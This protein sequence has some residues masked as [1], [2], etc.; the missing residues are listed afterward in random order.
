M[1]LRAGRRSPPRRRR[2]P[3]RQRAARGPRGARGVHA[4]R[5][6]ERRGAPRGRRPARSSPARPRGRRGSAP[7]ASGASGVAR[8]RGPPLRRDEAEGFARRARSGAAPYTSRRPEIARNPVSPAPGMKAGGSGFQG[9]ESEEHAAGRRARWL[10]FLS[11]NE[12]L[13]SGVDAVGVLDNFEALGLGVPPLPLWAHGEPA[14]MP[15]LLFFFLALPSRGSLAGP[16]RG[17]PSSGERGAHGRTPGPL[18]GAPLEVSD[19]PLR[20]GRLLDP[21]MRVTYNVRDCPTFLEQ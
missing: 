17:A 2:P 8:L 1:G 13:G 4:R 15:A 20:G 18:R 5:A 6:T 14:E 12:M 11:R 21:R 3:R 9:P 19:H 16:A 7:R 10:L